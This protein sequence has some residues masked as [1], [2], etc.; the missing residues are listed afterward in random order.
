MWYGVGI[1]SLA[2]LYEPFHFGIYSRIKETLE[3][4]VHESVCGSTGSLRQMSKEGRYIYIYLYIY[5]NCRRK[6]KRCKITDHEKVKEQPVWAENAWC[7][8]PS[9]VIRISQRCK[10]ASYF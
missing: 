3:W 9:C 6:K 2:R 1:Q 4:E 10:I 8:A 5:F 7:L